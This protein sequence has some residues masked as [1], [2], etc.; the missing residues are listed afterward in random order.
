VKGVGYVAKLETRLNDSEINVLTA[1]SKKIDG[2]LL[3][4][5]EA[6]VKEEIE[7][8][9]LQFQGQIAD[10]SKIGKVYTQFLSEYPQWLLARYVNE[11]FG[12]KMGAKAFLPTVPE[13]SSWCN[14]QLE[15]ARRE[16]QNIFALLNAKFIG[17]IEATDEQKQAAVIMLADY[18]KDDFLPKSKG[19]N[20][21]AID[22]NNYTPSPHGAAIKQDL[23]NR[24]SAK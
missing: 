17:R 16:K 19:F 7:P 14:A 23:E 10:I 9:M 6:Q 1:Y 11:F 3:P 2:F 5:A 15:Q 20:R 24:K 22:L 12:G 21:P 4:C 8:L 18:R 13:I